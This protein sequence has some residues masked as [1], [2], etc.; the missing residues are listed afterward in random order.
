MIG[1]NLPSPADIESL[2]RHLMLEL[3]SLASGDE[4]GAQAQKTIELDQQ[5]IG[6]L[7]RMDAMQQQAMAQAQARRRAARRTRI[8]A[9]LRR[10]E[11]DEFGI[12]E[13]CGDDIAPRRLAL[14]P[15]VPKCLS[16]ASG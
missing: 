2:K 5:S 13:D 10:M 16:C 12:C 8:E 15:T 3:Q 14:D 4:T 6:R 7:S 1:Q 9:T 11:D